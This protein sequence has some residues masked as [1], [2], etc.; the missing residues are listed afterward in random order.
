MAINPRRAWGEAATRGGSRC[1]EDS[2][3]GRGILA[4]ALAAAALCVLAWAPAA[5]AFEF[6]A[7]TPALTFGAGGGCDPTGTGTVS[8]AEGK[9]DL[10][11]GESTVSNVVSEFGAFAVGQIITGAGH[12]RRTRRS[13]RS[14]PGR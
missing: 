4:G 6:H 9:G 2:R 10:V 3:T 12:L 14:A 13:A 5:Q 7:K 11:E 1:T 8:A